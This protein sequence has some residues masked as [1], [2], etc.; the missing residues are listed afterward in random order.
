MSRCYSAVIVVARHRRESVLR[1][2]RRRLLQIQA[3]TEL[4]SLR[5]STGN[6]LE[7]LKADREGWQ[8]IG[9]GYR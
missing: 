5:V 4:A 6:Q 7:A 9:S 2:A 8:S 3:A 1:V